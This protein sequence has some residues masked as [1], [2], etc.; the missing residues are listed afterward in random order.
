MSLGILGAEP[1]QP[2]LRV[3]VARRSG[4]A[5]PERRPSGITAEA[6]HARLC[7]EDRIVRLGDAE[8]CEPVAAGSGTLIGGACR[9]DV[10]GAQQLVAAPDQRLR[11]RRR[12][13][14]K[15]VV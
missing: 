15:S 3:T 8:R 12:Q 7:Q 2:L 11:L 13:D 4:L 6:A 9:R 1:P 10:A 5:V 14:R